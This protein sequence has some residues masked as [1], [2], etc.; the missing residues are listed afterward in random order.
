Q[1]RL[2]E[3]LLGAL[4]NRIFRPDM[5][6]Y[7]LE[8]FEAELLKRLAEIEKQSAGTC[9]LGAL[10]RKQ[11]ELQAQ[12]SRLAEAIA[13]NGHS[14]TLLAHLASVEAQLLQVNDRIATYKPVNV[15]VTVKEIRSFAVSNVLELRTLLRHDAQRARTAL[16]KHV[17]ALVLTP[18]D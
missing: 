1:D 4:E 9:N 12:A 18:K 7:V 3:Q 6:E 15:T 14:P 13:L 2:E 17:K 16:M 10:R 8:R 5:I 11:D